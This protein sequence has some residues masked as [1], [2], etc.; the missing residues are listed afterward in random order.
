MSTNIIRKINNF[1]VINNSAFRKRIAAGWAEYSMVEYL[2]NKIQ[3]IHHALDEVFV[4]SRK[5]LK[6]ISSDFYPT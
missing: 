1:S 3:D 2:N 5:L 6:H 4:N